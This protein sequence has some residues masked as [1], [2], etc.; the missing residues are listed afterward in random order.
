M[1]KINNKVVF[2]LF[3][4]IIIIGLFIYFINYKNTRSI[5][6]SND[7]LDITS[8]KELNIGAVEIEEITIQDSNPILN[9]D[10]IF[11]TIKDYPNDAPLANPPNDIKAIYITSWTASSPKALTRIIKIRVMVIFTHALLKIRCLLI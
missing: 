3:L 6:I 10:D 2:G 9:F 7:K 11:K 5:N 4:F 1:I 8:N